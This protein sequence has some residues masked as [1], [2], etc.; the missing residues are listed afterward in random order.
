MTILASLSTLETLL[1]QQVIS[2][3][4][5]R[6]Y[7]MTYWGLVK[8]T[9]QRRALTRIDAAVTRWDAAVAVRLTRSG[10]P[11][12]AHYALLLQA[13]F[14][15]EQ[16]FYSP[17]QSFGLAGWCSYKIRVFGTFEACELEVILS[18]IESGSNI[19]S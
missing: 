18:G 13:K 5:K 8:V 10:A 4:V 2:L 16:S 17:V 6:C 7:S 12:L 14:E 3:K 9:R 19:Q 11:P 1:G 15:C